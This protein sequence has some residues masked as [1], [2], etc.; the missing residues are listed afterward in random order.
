MRLLTALVPPA[1]IVMLALLL[2]SL[3]FGAAS[4]QLAVWQLGMPGPGLAPLLFSACLLPVSVILLAEPLSEEERAPL[5][6]MPLI[7]GLVLI[8]FVVLVQFIGLMLPAALFSAGWA[9][10]LYR[11]SRVVALAAGIVMPALLYAV[12]VLGLRIPIPLWPV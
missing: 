6:A 2:V 12:F 1:R 5:Q 10:L 3:G 11:R 9:R 4:L 7:V 8:V